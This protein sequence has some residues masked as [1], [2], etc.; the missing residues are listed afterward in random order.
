MGSV[1]LTRR[2]QRLAGLAT[3]V[4]LMVAGTSCLE[5][6]IVY[7]VISHTMTPLAVSVMHLDNLIVYDN[8]YS[9]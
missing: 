6:V 4:R 1:W 5:N 2:L 9:P 7:L 8:L 3:C